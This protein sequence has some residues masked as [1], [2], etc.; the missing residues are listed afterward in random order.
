MTFDHKEILESKRA[1]RKKLAALPIAVKP[2]KLD[3]LRE[4]AITIWNAA[5]RSLPNRPGTGK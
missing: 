3:A 5:S 4:R 1:M 2:K